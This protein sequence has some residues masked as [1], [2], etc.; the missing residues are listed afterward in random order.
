MV[1]GEGYP[2]IC[3]HNPAGHKRAARLPSSRAVVS[4]PWKKV[5]A[6]DG[7]KPL[8]HRPNV[9]NGKSRGHLPQASNRRGLV[10]CSLFQS[11]SVDSHH[12]TH[13]ERSGHWAQLTGY[14][15]RGAKEG[16][17]VRVV[18]STR[19]YSFYYYR[20]CPCNQSYQL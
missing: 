19:Y 20:N 9:N 7:G 8:Q 12:A 18:A 2:H 3:A 11:P 10:S 17:A 15:A 16:K 4:V 5:G 6:C 14:G 13:G 1:V